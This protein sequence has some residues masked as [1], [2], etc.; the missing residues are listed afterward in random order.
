MQIEQIKPFILNYATQR[1][2][3]SAPSLGGHYC[4][5]LHMW[6]EDESNTPI[7]NI[8]DARNAEL[9]TKTNVRVEQDDESFCLEMLTKTKVNVESDDMDSKLCHLSELLTKTDVIQESDDSSSC[10]DIV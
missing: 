4:D 9:L 6:V 2:A 10:M 5:Q 3:S 7:I 8:V 1:V